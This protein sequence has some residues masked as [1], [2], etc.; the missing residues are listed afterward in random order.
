MSTRNRLDA[1]KTSGSPTCWRK[2]SE[3]ADFL[4][5]D[6]IGNNLSLVTA[7]S[8]FREKKQLGFANSV[9]EVDDDV[10]S[11]VLCRQIVMTKAESP[12]SNYIFAQIQD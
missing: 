9:F 2:G 12:S 6:L 7:S 1:E 5:A 4:E 10:A 8:I 11:L 3:I